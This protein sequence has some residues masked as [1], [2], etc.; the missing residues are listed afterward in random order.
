MV[1]FGPALENVKIMLLE[2]VVFTIW[3]YPQNHSTVIDP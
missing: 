2:V 3:C 1:V